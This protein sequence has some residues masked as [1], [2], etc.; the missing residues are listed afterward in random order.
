M[1][2]KVSIS[3]VGDCSVSVTRHTVVSE[4][5]EFHWQV[6]G[7]LDRNLIKED[8]SEKK[9]NSKRRDESYILE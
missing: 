5:R 4:W 7:I 2:V 9:L 6:E 3:R 8:L 1:S